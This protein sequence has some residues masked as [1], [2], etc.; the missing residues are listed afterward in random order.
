MVGE[1]ATSNDWVGVVLAGGT[2]SR[3]KPLTQ[4]VNKHLLPVYDKPMIYYSLSTLMLAGIRE[5]VLVSSPDALPQ[6]ERLLGFGSTWGMHFKYVQQDTPDGIGGAL[7]AASPEF[8]GRSTMVVLGDNIF[9]RARLSHYL[10]ELMKT[11]DGATVIGHSV[12]DP[13]AFGV[14]E[15]DGNGKPIALV[16]KPKQP[17]S[18]LAIPGLYMF[19]KTLSDI[20]GDQCKSAR[21]E[22]EITGILDHY[23]KSERLKVSLPGRG[24]AWLDGGTVDDLFEASQFVKLMSDRTGQL[25]ASPEE[26]A[27]RMGWIDADKARKAVLPFATSPYG[28][29]VL[30]VIEDK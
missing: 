13:T 23:L 19:D 8:K 2:G 7:R 10:T 25:L 24:F 1:A 18:N 4:V 30:H 20:V 9:Y 28:E 16:E 17:R 26:I 29:R 6:F 5:I 15:L 14:V 3:M 27:W 12:A 11:N 22:Y 21:A